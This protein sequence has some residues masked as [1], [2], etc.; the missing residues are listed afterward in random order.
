MI[1]THCGKAM[2]CESE[3]TIDREQ[4]FSHNRN[5]IKSKTGKNNTAK[6]AAHK[7]TDKPH[8]QQSS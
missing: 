5:F 2:G 1:R 3:E 4:F 7:L 6:G 8:P